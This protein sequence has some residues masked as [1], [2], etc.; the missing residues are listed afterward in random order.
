MSLIT[1]LT[2][3]EFGAGSVGE[4]QKHLARLEIRRPLIISDHGIKAAGLLDKVM[5]QIAADGPVFLDVPTNPTE[6]ATQA[7]AQVYAANQCD[8]LLAIGGGS[9][10]DLAKGVALMATHG[11][12]LATYA[13]IEGGLQAITDKV[14]PVIA[15]PTTAGTG[16]EV[17]RAALIT[18]DDGRKLGFV[19]PHLIPKCAIC[20]PEFTVAMPQSLTAATALDAL[21]HCLETYLSP[22]YNPPADAIA[23]DG[24]VRIWNNVETAYNNGADLKARTELMMGSLQGGLTFQKGLGAIHALSH[25]MGGLGALQL[26]HGT[27]N[28]ILLP[29]V[30]RLNRDAALEKMERI[31]EALGL[32]NGAL[33]R[34]LADLNERLAIPKGLRTLGVTEQ[35]IDYI[36][37]RA[38]ADHSHATNPVPLTADQYRHLILETMI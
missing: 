24:A 22:R 2:E 30:M 37:E 12:S 18:L 10:I 17:G 13:L 4:L 35:H 3:I 26:H 28:A 38:L 33:P 32:E 29:G 14:A 19:S 16:A 8:G 23:L 11:G 27:L 9:P 7:A 1:Y 25:A 15:I 34:A 21:S 20:D 31:E 6:A 5:R 36:I